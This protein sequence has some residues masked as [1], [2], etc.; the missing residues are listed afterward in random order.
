MLKTEKNYP[1]SRRNCRRAIH[2]ALDRL[3]KL[4]NYNLKGSWKEANYGRVLVDKV[5]VICKD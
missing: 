5:V 3:N 1:T 2:L 4:L